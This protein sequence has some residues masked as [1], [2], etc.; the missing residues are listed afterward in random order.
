MTGSWTS[1]AT[2]SNGRSRCACPAPLLTNVKIASPKKRRFRG[3]RR[4]SGTDKYLIGTS[5]HNRDACIGCLYWSQNGW[6]NYLEITGHSR[7]KDGGRLL[8]FGGCKLYKAIGTEIPQKKEWNL[9]PK[10]PIP[11]KLPSNVFRQMEYL[12]SQGLND[13]E[14]AM[15]LGVGKSS[16]YRWRKK[17]NL[18]SNY[19]RE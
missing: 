4:C 11:E 6:C 8:P 14:I 9:K 7:I 2:T 3:G 1:Q 18:Q 10:N 19:H 5:K 12:H 17:A 13:R 15:E 16:V